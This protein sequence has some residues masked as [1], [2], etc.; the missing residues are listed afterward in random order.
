M[1]EKY[2]S[3]RSGQSHSCC[4]HISQTWLFDHLANSIELFLAELDGRPGTILFEMLHRSRARNGQHRAR[5]HE[6]PGQ[7][8]LTGLRM[9]LS[10]NLGK[11][12]ALVRKLT[13]RQGRP[14]N[15]ADALTSAAIYHLLRF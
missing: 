10:G 4:F 3:S 7:R 11:R 14:G 12:A 8:N 6:E 5:T 1:L 13:R 15:K 2:E 9:M